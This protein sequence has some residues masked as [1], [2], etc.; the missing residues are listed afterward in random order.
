M[1]RFSKMIRF[2]TVI[3]CL[4]SLHIVSSAQSSQ[5]TG[6]TGI[7]R[8]PGVSVGKDLAT[9]GHPEACKATIPEKPLVTPTG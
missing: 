7:T 4:L 5:P 2:G 1:C 8:T 9:M 3:V 6:L